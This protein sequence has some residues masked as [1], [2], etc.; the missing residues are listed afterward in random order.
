MWARKFKKVQAKE[1]CEIH[2][3]SFDQNPFLAIFET[4]KN[5]ILPK[6][7]HEIDLKFN[8]TSFLPLTFLNFLA[9][10]THESSFFSCYD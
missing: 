9:H 7:I 3:N 10:C 1:I 4:A 6:R 8:F 2:E 5:G